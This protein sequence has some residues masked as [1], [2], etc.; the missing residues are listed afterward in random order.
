MFHKACFKKSQIDKIGDEDYCPA[1]YKTNYIAI[2]EQFEWL[3]EHDAKAQKGGSKDYNEHGGQAL[4][5]AAT[6][7]NYSDFNVQEEEDTEK[8]R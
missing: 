6:K 5:R 1:C 3:K 8:I 7:I 4:K 2:R